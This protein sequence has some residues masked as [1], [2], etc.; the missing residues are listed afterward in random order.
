MYTHVENEGDSIIFDTE[1]GFRFCRSEQEFTTGS[2]RFEI[3]YLDG[4]NQ[5]VS[6]GICNNLSLACDS[7]VYYFTGGYFYCSS[8]PS[9]TKDLTKI[10]KTT[11]IIVSNKGKIAI[12]FN[13]DTKKLFW[14][15]DGKSYE[16]CDIAITED[17]DPFYIVVGMFKGKVTF[18]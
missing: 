12:N 8:Y 5:Q 1:E 7:N 14:E 2:H 4:A 13:L 6:F 11:P 15:L 3:D 10:H 18:V 17:N 16:E 9:F